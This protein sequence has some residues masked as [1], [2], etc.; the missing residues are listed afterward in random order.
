MHE[1]IHDVI[2][3]HAQP[4]II[5]IINELRDI[6]TLGSLTCGEQVIQLNLHFQHWPDDRY[7]FVVPKC[8]STRIRSQES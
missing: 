7:Y 4:C 8:W 2:T 5:Y 1:I 3:Y 6:A